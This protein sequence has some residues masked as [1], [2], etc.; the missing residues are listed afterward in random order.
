MMRGGTLTDRQFIGLELE[1]RSWREWSVCRW[2]CHCRAKDHRRV[3]RIC[4]ESDRPNQ[5]FRST[6]RSGDMSPPWIS[7]S[8]LVSAVTV[9]N[10]LGDE[11]LR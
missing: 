7:P 1:C 6:P 3:M 2:G 8:K 11:C 9:T 5:E 10:V 4:S